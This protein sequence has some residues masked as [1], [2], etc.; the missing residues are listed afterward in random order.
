MHYLKIACRKELFYKMPQN[1]WPLVELSEKLNPAYLACVVIAQDDSRDQGIY[2]NFKEE[3]ALPLPCLVLDSSKNI[4]IADKVDQLANE[5]E[6]KVIPQFLLDLVNFSNKNSVIFST[7]GHHNGQFFDQ[8]PAGALLREFYGKNFFRAD[9][10]D[11]VYELGDMMTHVG[12][13]LKAQQ[14]AARAFNADKV[15]FVTNGTTGSNTICANALLKQ[16]D[17]CLFDRNNHKSLYNSAL[18]MTGAK[19]V[20]LPT[21]RNARGLIG[22]LTAASF[23]E[24]NIRREIAKVDPQNAQAKRPF[25]LAVLQ[26]ETY[27]GVFYDA[28]YLIKKLGKL[29]DYILFD[30][31]WGGYE[32][33][34]DVLRAC[35]PFQLKL[36]PEDPGIL[37]TQSV[38]KQQAGLAQASQI[39]KKDSHLKGQKRYVDHKHFNHT[40]L[41]YVTT[42]YSY[43]IYSSLVANTALVSAP[44]NHDRWQEAV[45]LSIEFR[46]ALFKKSKMFRPFVPVL[47]H[48]KKWQDVPTELLATDPSA[49]KLT[50]ED[51]WHG[52]KQISDEECYLSPLKLTITTP[53]VDDKS[54]QF[55]AQGVPGVI[56]EEYLHEHGIVPEKSDLYSTLYLITPGETKAE[57]QALLSALL[58]FES[59]YK[60]HKSVEELLPQV[61]ADNPQRYQDYTLDQLCQEMH[62]YYQQN[63]IFTLMRDLFIKKTFQDYQLTPTAADQA[64]G[65]NDSE[66]VKLEDLQD[67]VALEGA[68]PYPPGVFVVA[69]GEKWQQIDIDYFKILLTATVKFPG[70]DPE[71]QGVYQKEGGKQLQ[72]YGEVLPKNS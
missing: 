55:S 25:R 67:R 71:V 65:R 23:S 8:H 58:N 57:M 27:D 17:L 18:I 42:S 62:Q 19:P 6:K 70:F 34:I 60:E 51:D 22:P 31:A 21:D 10:S 16:G 38:H 46:K 14:E 54:R 43:P 37:V 4:N 48:S 5:Y 59:A 30:C 63:K 15:Y 7:P 66:L 49:W 53:G 29:C 52:F 61:Y 13:P 20:Y 50:K 35:S 69:P 12:A 72:V 68:L 36:G 24:E 64:F 40:Y 11:S 56:V 33:F 2:E 1:N 45:K 47:V 26:L 32:Q 44:N 28:K 3:L 39:L 41:Q 9:V